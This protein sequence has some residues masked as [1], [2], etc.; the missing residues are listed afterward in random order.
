M[1]ESSKANESEEVKNAV[2]EEVQ[3]ADDEP[4]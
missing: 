4:N 3:I 1:V 2:Y